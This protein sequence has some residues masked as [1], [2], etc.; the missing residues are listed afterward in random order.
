MVR[1]PIPI[2]L[3]CVDGLCTF[4]SV[5]VLYGK[6]LRV[7]AEECGLTH[8]TGDALRPLLHMVERNVGRDTGWDY[9]VPVASIGVGPLL[10]KRVQCVEDERGGGIAVCGVQLAS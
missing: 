2:S 5:D 3:L 9:R 8:L 7:K 1:R 6:D 4:T 10:E